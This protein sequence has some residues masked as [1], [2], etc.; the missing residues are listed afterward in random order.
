MAL[1]FISGDLA[2]FL[3][4]LVL[5]QIF[6]VHGYRKIVKKEADGSL[7]YIFLGYIEALTGVLMIA[8]FLTDIVALAFIIIMF[9]AL[10]LKA[11][12][13]RKQTY[14]SNMEYDILILLTA[15][16]VL[17]LGPGKFTVSSFF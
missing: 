8:G 2:L 17:V 5:G 15:F 3:L 6:L 11:F 1:G 9:G 16:V 7:K 4:R 12:V 13:W 14:V 10:Y